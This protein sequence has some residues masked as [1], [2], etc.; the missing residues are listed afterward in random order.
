MKYAPLD[1][2]DDERI[3]TIELII[4]IDVKLRENLWPF[5]IQFGYIHSSYR[6]SDPQSANAIK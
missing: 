3:L 5:L 1:G 2:D 4:I 6:S